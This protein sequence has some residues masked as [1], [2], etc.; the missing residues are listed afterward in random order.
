MTDAY[1]ASTPMLNDD[2][3]HLDETTS[4]L[5]DE[6]GKKRFQAAVGS[7]SYLMHA[8]RPDIAYTII[9]LS[10]YASQPRSIHWDGI[11]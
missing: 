11:K 10:Q 8:T 6:A 5:L 3:K 1:P 2:K 9:R 4:P 7:I